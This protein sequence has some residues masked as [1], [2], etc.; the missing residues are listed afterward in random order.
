MLE[1]IL[2]CLI[3]YLINYMNVLPVFM[4]V[5]VGVIAMKNYPTH[6]DMY[7]NWISNVISK[8]SRS[9]SNV[10]ERVKKDDISKE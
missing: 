1:F 2:G 10:L 9:I 3:G 8:T 4:G 5:A 6:G 7:L